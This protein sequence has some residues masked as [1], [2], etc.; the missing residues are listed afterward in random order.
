M[1]SGLRCFGGLQHGFRIG[2]L[3]L[4]ADMQ[5]EKTRGRQCAL[6]R[7][8]AIRSHQQGL[9]ERA[10]GEQI[11]VLLAGDDIAVRNLPRGIRQIG[12]MPVGQHVRQRG[13]AQIRQSV[14][15][16]GR[17]EL[18]KVTRP[19]IRFEMLVIDVAVGAAHQQVG[20][21]GHQPAKRCLIVGM[22]FAGVLQNGARLGQFGF[23]IREMAD[24]K[25]HHFAHHLA[26]F[27][28]GVDVV[29]DIAHAVSRKLFAV[30]FQHRILHCRRNP[31]VYAVG[32]DVIVLL[33]FLCQVQNIGLAKGDIFDAQLGA[34]R[35]GVGDLHLR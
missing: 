22:Q 30:E 7:R 16:R 20:F 9:P 11:N 3:E 29:A 4:R 1:N 13:F 24:V 32:D 12:A 23:V 14:F 25:Q 33:R 2:R 6:H 27:P 34:D 8:R 5:M 31:T 21:F 28:A 10:I 35:V 19:V 18:M 17:H 26:H 15:R